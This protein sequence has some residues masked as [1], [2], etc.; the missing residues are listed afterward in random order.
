MCSGVARFLRKLFLLFRMD[1]LTPDLCER[2]YVQL[3]FCKECQSK[4]SGQRTGAS[5]HRLVKRPSC[6][7]GHLGSLEQRKELRSGSNPLR[8]QYWPHETVYRQ[9]KENVDN[10]I[11]FSG[12]V[13]RYVGSPLTFFSFSQGTLICNQAWTSSTLVILRFKNDFVHHIFCLELRCCVL[14][15]RRRDLLEVQENDTAWMG[16]LRC[17]GLLARTSFL[18][19]STTT[20]TMLS[21]APLVGLKDNKSRS[22]KVLKTKVRSEAIPSFQTSASML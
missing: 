15:I 18:A 1:N 8:R 21:L 11:R 10:I 13:H 6:I 12:C 17:T 2:N 4:P 7:N 5:W 19:K 20:R 9:V 14:T 22:T 3:I 16:E